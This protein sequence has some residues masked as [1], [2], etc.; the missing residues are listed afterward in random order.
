LHK[1]TPYFDGCDP[2]LLRDVIM[3]ASKQKQQ[4]KHQQQQP[5]IDTR[6]PA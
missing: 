2:S 5:A 6:L 1:K 3:Q 4:Q